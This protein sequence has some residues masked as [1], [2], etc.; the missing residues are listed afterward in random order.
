MSKDPQGVF[1]VH[2]VI[3]YK[4]LNDKVKAKQVCIH[5]QYWVSYDEANQIYLKLKELNPNLELRSTF[6][7]ND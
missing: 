5:T 7:I 6:T 2:S 3:M 1:K 4:D